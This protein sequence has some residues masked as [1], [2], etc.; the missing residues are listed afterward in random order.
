M[1]T[2]DI[3]NTAGNLYILQICK[4]LWHLLSLFKQY[5]RHI[6]HQDKEAVIPKLGR[7]LLT[8]CVIC[9]ISYPDRKFNHLETIKISYPEVG[10]YVFVS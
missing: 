6:L 8:I 4:L 2:M 10:L 7:F 5:L 1:S 9:Q 3:F